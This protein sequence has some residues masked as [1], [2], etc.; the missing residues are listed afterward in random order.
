MSL[1][2]SGEMQ[3]RREEVLQESP[4]AVQHLPHNVE[5]ERIIVEDGD[6]PVEIEA[7]KKGK[8]ELGSLELPL[9]DINFTF[10]NYSQEDMEAFMER[11]DQH[12][13]RFGGGP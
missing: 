9:M 6:P 10:R 8:R 2:F 12:T 11:F 3:W 4:R 7:I 13:F 1:Q 5:G